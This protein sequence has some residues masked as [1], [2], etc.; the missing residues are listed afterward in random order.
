MSGQDT[1]LQMSMY[2]AHSVL[3][4]CTNVALCLY[5][6]ATPASLE[7]EGTSGTRKR[8]GSKQQHSNSCYLLCSSGYQLQ[9]LANLYQGD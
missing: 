1:M 5:Y 2:Q 4:I 6:Y 7:R 8:R 9:H 3:S